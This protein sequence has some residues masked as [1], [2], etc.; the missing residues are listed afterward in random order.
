LT[1][2]V[3]DLPSFYSVFC[4]MGSVFFRQMD[5]DKLKKEC[6]I[7]TFKS[8][9]PGGQHRNT[10]ESAVRIRHV[11]SGITLI[12]QTHRSQHRNI[13]DALERLA[14]KL[15][16]RER[17]KNRE[18]RI[19]TRKSRAVRERELVGKKLRAVVKK[20]RRKVDPD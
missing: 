18:K 10:T 13:Q 12:G 15:E 7:T 6:E 16:E 8:S 20:S 5:F 9:G 19:P 2:K 17:E 11:P 3:K 14:G 4:I 1:G